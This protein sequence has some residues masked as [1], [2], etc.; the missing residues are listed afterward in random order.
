MSARKKTAAAIAIVL[1]AALLLGGAFAAKDFRQHAVN[2]TRNRVTPDAL[3]HDDF[4][5]WE[6]KDVYVENTGNDADIYVRIQFAE[7]LQIGN[8]VIVGT[9][10]QNKAAY[11]VHSYKGQVMDSAGL[12]TKWNLLKPTTA[13]KPPVYVPRPAADRHTSDYFSWEMTG[14]RKLFQPGTA[15]IAD[16]DYEAVSPPL[17]PG[18]YAPANGNGEQ[19]KWTADS[20]PVRYLDQ[21][22]PLLDAYILANSSSGKTG[23]EL[24]NEFFAG[25]KPGT[26]EPCWI[27]DNTDDGNG[28]AYWSVP[29]GPKDATN[30]L[31]DNVVIAANGKSLEDNFVYAIDVRMEA[32]NK[33]EL[34][35]FEYDINDDA[36]RMWFDKADPTYTAGNYNVV[37][38]AVDQPVRVYLVVSGNNHITNPLSGLQVAIGYDSAVMQPPNFGGP[39][40]TSLTM[41]GWNDGVLNSVLKEGTDFSAFSFMD[42]MGMSMGSTLYNPDGSGAGLSIAT[43]PDFAGKDLSVISWLNMYGLPIVGNGVVACFEFKILGGTPPGEYKVP[44][45]I[46]DYTTGAPLA[47]VTS[48]IEGTITVW[49]TGS[50]PGTDFPD[51]PAW[52]DLVGP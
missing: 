42:M 7:F 1:A 25:G 39:A 6:N 8:E 28:W 2:I 36:K 41:N 5:P 51:N 20:Q 49:P 10:F 24:R 48:V 33:R 22:L 9:K 26:I 43:T 45:V 50:V 12:A 38:S 21:V 18:D 40:A 4:S 46:L 52:A 32:T 16:V 3:L 23:N 27:L 11:E 37:T 14:D 29:L 17:G 13:T 15:D 19:L 47:G 35:E 31:L 34:Y 44:M 30:K